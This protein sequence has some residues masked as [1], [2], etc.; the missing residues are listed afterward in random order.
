MKGVEFEL[1]KLLRREK[2]AVIV[3][4]SVDDG[5][6]RVGG[7]EREIAVRTVRSGNGVLL[8]I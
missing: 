1:K 4:A 3:G 5:R 6:L 7:S 2:L 8:M